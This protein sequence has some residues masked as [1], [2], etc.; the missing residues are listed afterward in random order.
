MSDKTKGERNKS[1]KLTAFQVF[2]IKEAPLRPKLCPSL[3]RALNVTKQNISL[4]RKG[5]SWAWL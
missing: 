5:K 2:M 1:A 3:G 4:I